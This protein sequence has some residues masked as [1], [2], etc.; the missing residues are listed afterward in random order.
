[1][2]YTDEADKIPEEK[3]RLICLDPLNQHFY[4]PT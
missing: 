4:Q 2:I 1:M 3:I